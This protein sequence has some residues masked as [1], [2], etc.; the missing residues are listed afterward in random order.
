MNVP[1]PCIEVSHFK[2]D[3][4]ITVVIHDNGG[5]IPLDVITRLNENSNPFVHVGRD[6]TSTGLGLP[7]VRHTVEEILH[8]KFDITVHDSTTTV[9]MVFPTCQNLAQDQ[10]IQTASTENK[11]ILVVDDDIFI[12]S[13][14]ENMLKSA[15][16]VV[17]KAKDTHE[18]IKIFNDN[19]FDIVISDLYMPPGDNGIELVKQLRC[20]ENSKGEARA[21]FVGLS[22]T[23]CA[24]GIQ[25]WKEAGLDLFY[26]K[27]LSMKNFL[28]ALAFVSRAYSDNFPIGFPVEF[29]KANRDVMNLSLAWLNSIQSEQIYK[30]LMQTVIS[31]PVIPMLTCYDPKALCADTLHNFLGKAAYLYA[32][33]CVQAGKHVY[34]LLTSDNLHHLRKA[35]D[36][37]ASEVN[38]LVNEIYLVLRL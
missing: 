27:P 2:L 1:S 25:K 34:A 19:Q 9:T 5:G 13:V 6:H 36:I 12:R 29:K 26:T 22:G 8:G 38:K 21:T 17:E 32:Q 20:I 3:G 11:L 15:G 33:Q 24:S 37:F 35:V 7:I 23:S 4:S 31:H 16:H 30:D 10:N 28:E 14:I 18:A